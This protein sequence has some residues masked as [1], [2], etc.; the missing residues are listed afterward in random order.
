MLLYNFV[1]ENLINTS[2][3]SNTNKAS[4]KLLVEENLILELLTKAPL[5]FSA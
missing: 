2:L 4:D 1:F 5:P 3:S